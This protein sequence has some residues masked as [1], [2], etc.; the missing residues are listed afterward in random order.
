MFVCELLQ[1]EPKAKDG[2]I[3]VHS[4]C[5]YRNLEFETVPAALTE[6]SLFLE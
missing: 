3:L 4:L 5:I 2:K 6:L 1:V